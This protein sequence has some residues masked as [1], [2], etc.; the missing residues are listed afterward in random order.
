MCAK[1]VDRLREPEARILVLK[2]A[3][4]FPGHEAT[5]SEIKESVPKYRKLTPGDLVRSKTRPNECMWQQ[6]VGNTVSHK[7][8]S[9][10]IFSKGFATRTRNR[11]RVTAKGLEFLKA[12]KL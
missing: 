11:I 9:N 10:S 5:V 2:I 4:D 12:N 3:A 6:I 8:S 1:K 7:K